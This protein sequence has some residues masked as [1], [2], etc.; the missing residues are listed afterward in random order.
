MSY[1][2]LQKNQIQPRVTEEDSIG[3]Y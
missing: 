3:D 2:D 1:L